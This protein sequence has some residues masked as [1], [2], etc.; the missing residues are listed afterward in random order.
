MNVNGV[1]EAEFGKTRLNG[2][3][4]WLIP[5]LMTYSS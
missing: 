1:K 5:M 3:Q 4:F 2:D